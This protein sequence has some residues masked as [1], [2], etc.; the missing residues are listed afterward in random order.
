MAS[1]LEKQAEITAEKRVLH[2]SGRPFLIG[3]WGPAFIT[4]TRH[5]L[6]IAAI[7]C[8]SADER[9]L[10]QRLADE[11][12]IESAA[13]VARSLRG[14]FHLVVAADGRLRVQGTASGMRR[15]FYGDAPGVTVASNR[16]DVIAGLLDA[17]LDEELL[18]VRLLD[19]VPHPLGDVPLWR[20]VHA[21]P[22]GFRLDTGPDGSSCTRWWSPPEP[23]LELDEGAAMLRTELDSAIRARTRAATTVS[24][25]LSGGLDSTAVCALAAAAGAT[26]VALTMPSRDPGDDDL[27]WAKLAAADLD[28]AEHVVLAVDRVPLFYSGLLEV[29]GPVDEPVPTILD[30]PRQLA[31]HDEMLARGAE[32]HFTGMGGDHVLWGHPAHALERLTTDPVRALRH[33]RGY[34]AHNRW[35]L[36]DAFSVISDRRPY[37]QWLADSADRLTASRAAPHSADVLAWDVPPR[38][39]GWATPDAVAAVRRR[40]RQAAQSA[41]PLGKTRAQHNEL[42]VLHHG[43]RVTRVL[44]QVAEQGGLPMASPFFDDRVIEACWA[45]RPEARSSPWQYK[46][47]LKAAMR[48][49]VPATVLGRDTKGE[50][51]TDAANGLRENRARIAELWHDSRLARMGLV[52]ADKLVR[53]TLQ[54]S[55]PELRYAGLDST[56]ACEIWLRTI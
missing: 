27:H 20:G 41:A 25:D 18:A 55:S 45:V 44:H 19:S 54:P 1:H 36:R 9:D 4:T 43:T 10:A 30:Q 35:S 53:I 39:P 17:P 37:G 16:A 29:T 12:D 47:L 22:P 51:S 5:G 33:I 56:L 2:P 42:N 40:M 6:R 23:R 28:H 8:S 50:A 48:G 32:L 15:V 38:L 14:E 7:G 46:P 31:G 26:P 21:V 3:S 34:R 13:R 49:V 24:S 52:D 11:R